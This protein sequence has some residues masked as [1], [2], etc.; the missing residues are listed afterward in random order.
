V[1]YYYLSVQCGVHN[2]CILDMVADAVLCGDVVSRLSFDHRLLVVF[3]KE[4]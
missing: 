1:C 3:S 2:H 4:R